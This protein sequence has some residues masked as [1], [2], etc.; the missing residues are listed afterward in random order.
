MMSLP[1]VRTLRVPFPNRA[2][3]ERSAAGSRGFLLRIVDAIAESNRR[4]AEREIA[5]FIARN[6]GELTDDLERRIP[7]LLP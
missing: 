4:K 6:G 7:R 2:A 3:A 1:L 5:R